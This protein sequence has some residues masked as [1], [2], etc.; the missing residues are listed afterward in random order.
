MSTNDQKTRIHKKKRLNFKGVLFLVFIIVMIVLGGKALLKINIENVEVLGNNYLS[1]SQ[2]IK[3]AGL[4]NNTSYFGFSSQTA[5]KNIKTSKLVEKCNIKRKFGLK[6]QIN[7]T[8]NRPLFYY[9]SEGVI[10]LSHRKRIND[11][12]SYPVPTLINY[13]PG[14][15]LDKFIDGLSSL[16]SDIISN[17]AEIE[18]SPSKNNRGAY[19]DET[20]F[21][22]EMNDGNIVYINIQNIEALDDY[23]KIYASVGDVKGYY[24]FDSER[25][26]YDS[27]TEYKNYLFNPFGEEVDSDEGNEKKLR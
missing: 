5:C 16:N 24:N 25:I 15:I 1:S 11:D 10:V 19:Y 6:I 20:R 8:E 27:E 13:T 7:I 14:E 18:Y 26:K 17:I 2:I 23:P 21:M 22:L 3:L 4:N 9:P 12:I